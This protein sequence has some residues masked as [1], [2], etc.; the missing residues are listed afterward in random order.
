MAAEK[1]KLDNPGRAVAYLMI[2][3]TAGLCLD[4]TAKWLLQDYALVQ[5]VFL[6]SVFGLTCLLIVVSQIGGISTLKT[7][8]IGWHLIRTVLAAC[9]MFGFFY[10]LSKMPLVNA[11]TVGFTAPLIVTALSVPFLGERVGWRRWSAVAM[12]FVGVVVVLRPESGTLN[13]AALAVLGSAFAYA[14]LAITARHLSDTES[15]YALSIYVIAGPMLIAGSLL[16]DQWVTPAPFDWLLFAFAGAASAVAWVGIM[17]G[18][19]RASPALLAPFEYTAL[20]GGALAGYLIWNEVPDRWVIL[21]G[22]III[23]SGLFVVYREVGQALTNR[24]LRGFTAGGAATMARR[25]TR[26]AKKSEKNSDE[27]LD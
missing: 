22:V 10:G 12:G 19:R 26:R 27:K 16:P 4:I 1:D 21:G 8:R 18:Y 20:L 9:A 2:G 3:I 24:Y 23:G 11:L 14:C 7:K 15:S 17:S 13:W 25:L 5:F 6:R